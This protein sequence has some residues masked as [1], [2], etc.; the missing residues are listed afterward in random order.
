MQNRE[1]DIEFYNRFEND[2]KNLSIS[3]LRDLIYFSDDDFFKIIN[4]IANSK[5][6]EMERLEKLNMI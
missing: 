4:G 3:Q 6:V 2:L 1:T 5:L